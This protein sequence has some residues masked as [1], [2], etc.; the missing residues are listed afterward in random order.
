M[1]ITSWFKNLFGYQSSEDYVKSLLFTDTGAINLNANPEVL[2]KLPSG[3]ISD[4]S[5]RFDNPAYATYKT[6]QYKELTTAPSI[7][8]TISKFMGE[9]STTSKY[10]LV[11]VAAYVLLTK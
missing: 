5:V 9:L 8:D 4:T 6:Q 1:S 7:S 2:A 11:G 10:L 3:L